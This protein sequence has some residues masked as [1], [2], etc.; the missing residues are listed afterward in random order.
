MQLIN[1]IKSFLPE[2]HAFKDEENRFNIGGTWTT[3]DG[4]K[5]FYNLEL[6]FIHNS[7]RLALQGSPRGDGS[8]AYISPSGQVHTITAERAKAFMD[9]THHQATI[10]CG[11]IDRLKESGF[12]SEP[13]EAT[14]KPG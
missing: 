14:A 6:R 5:D 9:Q 3:S 8:W 7:E 12:M 1:A 13:V 2:V 10:M 11:M 4:L